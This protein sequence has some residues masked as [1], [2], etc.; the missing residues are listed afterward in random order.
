MWI[1]GAVQTLLSFYCQ[2]TNPSPRIFEEQCKAW[3]DDLERFP[4]DVIDRVLNRWRRT[5]G[6][7]PS[8]SQII[9]LCQAEMSKPVMPPE[10]EP[11]RR[12]PT[13]EEKARIQQL[14]A[15]SGFAP[16]RFGSREER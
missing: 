9:R 16:G 10:P 5:E 15:D 1:V 2:E 12:P 3:A 6:R 8:P 13:D 11:E 14:L 4:R 7:R